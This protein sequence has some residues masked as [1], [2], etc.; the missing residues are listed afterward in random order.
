MIIKAK[1]N[2]FAIKMEKPVRNASATVLALVII[3][4]VIKE[5][6]NIIP[7]FQQAGLITLILNI[8]TMY[9]GFQTAKFLKL[10]NKQAIS[11]SI[12]SGIQNGT[13]AIMIATVLLENTS[14]AIAPAIYSL[15]M[16]FTGVAIIL[17]GKRL[18]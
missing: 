13:M 16:F 12:E 17:I 1:N 5:K 9:I 15:I 7:Y 14:F 4:I 2:A 11:I 6:S 18:T 8:T 10:N 3:G